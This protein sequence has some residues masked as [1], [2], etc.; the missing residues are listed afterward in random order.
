MTRIAIANG[1]YARAPTTYARKRNGCPAA[2][3]FATRFHVACMTADAS[4]RPSAIPVMR[5]N[6]RTRGSRLEPA[7]VHIERIETREVLAQAAHEIVGVAR[8]ARRP[9]HLGHRAQPRPLH[10][11]DMARVGHPLGP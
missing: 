7:V 6:E 2:V 11:F 5:W 3:R 10:V 8:L 1:V 9:E 4:T